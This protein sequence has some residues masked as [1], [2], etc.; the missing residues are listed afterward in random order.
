MGDD[1][2]TDEF[3]EKFQT[4]FAP[5]PSFSEYHI[6][7][8]SEKSQKNPVYRS[9]IC[10]IFLDWKIIPS[11]FGS[12]PKIHPFWYRHPSLAIT[13]RSKTASKLLEFKCCCKLDMLRKHCPWCL[14]SWDVG[15]SN[16]VGHFD[17]HFN[18]T[19]RRLFV[20]FVWP[21]CWYSGSST[22]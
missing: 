2:K 17:H 16:S 9:K 21:L 11:S 3:S 15:N 8:F 13:M 10:N 6:A 5:P 14:L 18:L 4:A 20:S 1:T 22:F 7:F 19:F 12:F